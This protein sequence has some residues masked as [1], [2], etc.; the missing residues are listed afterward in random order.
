MIIC[1]IKQI[2]FIDNGSEGHKLINYQRSIFYISLFSAYDDI[3][4][5]IATLCENIFKLADTHIFY[6]L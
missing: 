1:S 6:I 3:K 4:Q 5:F 2:N